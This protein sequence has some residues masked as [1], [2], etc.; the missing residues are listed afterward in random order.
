[1]QALVFITAMQIKRAINT[2]LLVIFVVSISGFISHYDKANMIWYIA[3]MF[4][5]GSAI[6]MILATKFKKSFNDKVLKT[7][8]AIM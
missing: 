5:D 4:I 6:V 2:S 3:S 8:Y 1:V 7:I